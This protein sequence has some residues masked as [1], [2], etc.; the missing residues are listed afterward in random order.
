MPQATVTGLRSVELAVLD[1]KQSAEFYRAVW[2]LEPIAS[3]GTPSICVRTG[4]E[5]HAV[6]L[7]ERPRAALLGVNFEARD[8][9]AV[10]A[11]HAQAKALGANVQSAP[12]PLEASAGGGYGFRL[13]TPEGHPL[14]ISSDVVRHAEPA[15]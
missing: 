7:R 5:H 15:R 11:L 4:R 3:E 14:S 8:R 10:D 6:T 9:A 13:S 12:A 2:G 1:L